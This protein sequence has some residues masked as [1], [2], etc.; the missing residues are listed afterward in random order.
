MQWV[1][2]VHCRP[3]I[4]FWWHSILLIVILNF[5]LFKNR[6]WWLCFG[7][8]C[9]FVCL[10]V[11]QA[12]PKGA[13]LRAT[14]QRLD[15]GEHL[16]YVKKASWKIAQQMNKYMYSAQVVAFTTASRTPKKLLT[17]SSCI[18]SSLSWLIFKTS[19][20]QKFFSQEHFSAY[21]AWIDCL[22][23]I[24]FFNFYVF[25]F[26][27]HLFSV[28]PVTVKVIWL[29]LKWVEWLCDLN[30]I[31]VYFVLFTCAFRTVFIWVLWNQNQSNHWNN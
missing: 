2:T 30:F 4:Q 31:N 20:I 21:P 1:W 13:I 25:H 26:V 10:F 16:H 12:M 27:I 8:V 18:Q 11:Q 7:F 24:S 29:W 14:Q 22:H 6:F 19:H 3:E 9:L 28:H 5:S 17:C 23:N 15:K